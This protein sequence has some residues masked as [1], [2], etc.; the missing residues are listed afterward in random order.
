VSK[1]EYMGELGGKCKK[2]YCN[3]I[4]ISKEPLC[5]KEMRIVISKSNKCS[6]PR[7]QTKFT[8]SDRF[9]YEGN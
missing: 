6:C 4:I 9:C 1:E 3:Y 2:K 5:F 7:K 8:S